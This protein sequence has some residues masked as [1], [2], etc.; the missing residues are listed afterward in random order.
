MKTYLKIAKLNDAT[1][2]A[3]LEK[4]LEAVPKV[5]SVRIEPAE[6]QA[7]VEHDGA[8]E[9]ELSR[10]VK[11]LGYVAAVEKGPAA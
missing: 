4:S 1:D 8:N 2:A 7:V 10:A 3:H 9:D 5:T 6:N 11:Q